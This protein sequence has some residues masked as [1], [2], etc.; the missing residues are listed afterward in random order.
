MEQLSKAKIQIEELIL[1]ERQQTDEI[2]R[3]LNALTSER[4]S[5]LLQQEE[6]KF[7]NKSVV[8]RLRR[9][10]MRLREQH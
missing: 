8:T 6:L 4:H 5:L 3:K 1:K 9:L 7:K 2:N 10:F